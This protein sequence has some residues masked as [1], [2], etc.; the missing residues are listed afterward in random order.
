[1][2]SAGN[3]LANKT[4]SV[5]FRI[6]DA[7]TGGTSLW[8]ETQSVTTNAGGVFN[9]LLGSS[10]PIPD[11]A[12]KDTLRWLSIKVGADAEMS[13]RQ[14]IVSNAY[15]Y[16]VG[17]VDGATGGVISGN[18]AIQSDLTVSGN[19]GIGTTAPTTNLHVEGSVHATGNITR[20][21]T[22]GTSDLAV[23]I[24]YAFINSDGS[25]ASGTPNVTSSWDATNSRYVITISGESYSASSY[26]TTVS[27]RIGASPEALF[28]TTNSSSGNLLIRIY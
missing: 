3:P 18:T 19:V 12:F 17:T 15:G 26:V 27:P 16:R 6:Y 7:L 11:S 5:E 8:S 13:P 10:N 9:V 21:Y 22:V 2:D 4:K 1:M 14:Q 24:A 20:A 23:P 25:L 28:A